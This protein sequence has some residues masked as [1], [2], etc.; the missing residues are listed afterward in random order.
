MHPMQR[1]VT[2][3]RP[4]IGLGRPGKAGGI[5]HSQNLG[6]L[7]HGKHQR[8]REQQQP[9]LLICGVLNQH[10]IRSETFQL[11]REGHTVLR[12]G[13]AFRIG[14]VGRSLVVSGW[15]SRL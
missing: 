15:R 1:Y 14:V 7:V 2:K 10:N 11:E 9:N 5:P 4:T 13:R 3:A 8:A 6:A 12:F